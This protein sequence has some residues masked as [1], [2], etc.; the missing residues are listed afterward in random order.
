MRFDNPIYDHGF[1]FPDIASFP[2]VS[3]EGRYEGD[4]LTGLTL[5]Q[6]AVKHRDLDLFQK[7]Y[8]YYMKIGDGKLF[9][10]L[11]HMF[12]FY[13]NFERG[14]TDVDIPPNKVYEDLFEDGISYLDLDL[15]ELRVL[16]QPHIDQLLSIPDWRPP[17]G[18]I[19]RYHQLDE[20][21]KQKVHNLFEQSGI[22][23]GASKY[24]RGGR[25][26]HVA[27]AILHVAKPT[28]QN[29]KQFLYDCDTVTETINMHIDPK[30][31]VIKAMVYLDEVDEESGPFSYVEKSNRWAYDEVQSIFGRSITTGSYCCDKQSRAVVFQ[32]PEYLRVSYNFGRLL[33]DNTPEQDR[34]LEQRKRFVSSK[35]NVCVF[36]PAGMHQGGICK[37]KNRIALQVLMK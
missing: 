8:T 35:G 31:D 12:N 19:D 30:E 13:S 34:L 27:N 24:N 9:S 20:S 10:K 29:W 18:T 7:G 11:N 15:D 32:L 25:R 4:D 17:P 33:L 21:Y 14:R 5:I 26:L 1:S 2:D 22:I 6:E 3:S 23:D 28:D 16:A 36:D 37:S